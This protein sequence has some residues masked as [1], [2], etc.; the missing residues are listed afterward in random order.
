MKNS[1]KGRLL[2]GI[3]LTVDVAAPLA[4]TVS[5]FPLWIERSSSATVSGLFLLFAFLSCIPFWRQIKAFMKS[6]SAPL[7][8][9]VLFVLFLALRNIVDEM[10]IV[11]LVGAL[12]NLIG[13]GLYKLGAILAER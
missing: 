4:A 3:G 5:Q 11:C 8:W 10:L 13:T 7:L 6:P 12:S 9:S 2:K 1:A